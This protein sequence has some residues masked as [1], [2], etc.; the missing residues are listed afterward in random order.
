MEILD[1]DYR[2][3]HE[4]IRVQDSFLPRTLQKLTDPLDPLSQSSCHIHVGAAIHASMIPCREPLWR[5]CRPLSNLLVWI[6]SMVSKK[7]PLL[8]ENGTKIGRM[9]AVKKVRQS[10]MEI[11][12]A[13]PVCPHPITSLPDAWS[14]RGG[15]PIENERRQRRHETYLLSTE[16]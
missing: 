4:R 8:R 9:A 5:N 12:R 1:H 2:L 3:S 6:V 11:S 14:V 15:V 13:K 10:Q 7:D 16:A